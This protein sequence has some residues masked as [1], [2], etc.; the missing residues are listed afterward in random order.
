MDAV[1]RA[2][3]DAPA[4][5]VVREGVALHGARSGD[6]LG[7]ELGI[8]D[9]LRGELELG[10]LGEELVALLT[11]RRVP[12][13]NERGAEEQREG[14]GTEET[15]RGG[16]TPVT[17]GAPAAGT[18]RRERITSRPVSRNDFAAFWTLVQVL[19]KSSS[20][21][22]A[23]DVDPIRRP[24]SKVGSRSYRGKRPVA[25]DGGKPAR[26]RRKV[27]KPAAASPRK[28]PEARPAAPPRRAKLPTTAA[29]P[30]RAP[31]PEEMLQRA[32][33]A[34]TPRARGIW[35]RRGLA[36]RKRLD[37]T[38]QSMLLRQLYLAY[39]EERRFDKALAVSQQNIELC[40]LPD[41]AHQDAARAAQALGEV[42][43][44]A[45]HLR[46]AARVGPAKR[47]AF[48]WW[49]LGSVYFLAGRHDAAVSALTRAARWG[50]TDKPLYQGHLAVAR[51]AGGEQVPE[52]PDL[53]QRLADVPAGQGYGRFVLGHLAYYAQRW[54]EAKRYLDAFV[55]R[56]EGGRAA[57]A[58][59]L[60]GE[61][62]LA[63]RTLAS[64]P[65]D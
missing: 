25:N 12:A 46:L 4:Q 20:V 49:T 5:A 27:A 35:A 61:I 62:A 10:I 1:Q 53:I 11:R 40:V 19:L 39:Y 14:R 13:P 47:R 34:G 6:P 48:H 52:L 28:R 59:A 21:R 30:A 29:R 60:G 15:G 63:R 42:D 50:T 32:M 3:G 41:V 7:D 44:A 23:K 24:A 26:V 9:P 64:L 16:H 37:T 36:S 8:G 2:L 18:Q 58:I 33:V 55:A 51:C 43:T 56:S 31:A 54:D 45:G 65:K 17:Y 22:K 38:T 57:L